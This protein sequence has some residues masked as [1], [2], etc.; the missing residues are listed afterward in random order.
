MS[1]VLVGI[2]WFILVPLPEW[3]TLELMSQWIAKSQR[4]RDHALSD[5]AA[6]QGRLALKGRGQGKG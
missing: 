4:S 3:V 2:G 1:P 6:T 5:L